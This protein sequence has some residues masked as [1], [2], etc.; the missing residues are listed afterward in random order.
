[1]KLVVFGPQKRVGIVRGDTVIDASLATAKYLHE[2]KSEP[3]ALAL[4]AALA[5][6]DL[7]AFILGGARALDHAREAIDYLFAGATNRDGVTGETLLHPLPGLRLWAPRTTRARVA[8]AGGNF[9]AHS[10]AMQANR[11]ARTGSHAPDVGGNFRERGMWGG[12]KIDR[13]AVDPGG[14]VI[15]PSRT[16]L[17]D[18]EGELAVIL[19][20]RG[21]N[22]RAAD[23][24]SHVWGVTLFIDWSARNFPEKEAA[25]KFNRRKNFDNSYSM[26]PCIVVGELD[27][28]NID[29]ETFVNGAQRQSFNTR[30]MIFSFDEYIEYL[31]Q[32]L[33]L[34][35]G[36]AISSGT[37]RGTAMDSSA[38]LPDGGIAP[39]LFLKPGDHVS[40]RCQTIGALDATIAAPDGP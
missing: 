25:I 1:M 38:R 13:D 7:E 40:V 21:K 35:P 31:S 18:Y 12:W 11:G 17:F 2:R 14:T 24:R 8:F 15:Y 3:N 37:G 29:I 27:P 23:A 20:K 28:A 36:D 32:D 30:D 26:G 39:E 6:P 19:G 22:I 10:L 5:P 9:A 34:Y 16:T 4:A 33:T